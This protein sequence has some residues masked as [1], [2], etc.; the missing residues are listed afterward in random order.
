MEIWAPICHEGS[1]PRV[2]VCGIHDT[3]DQVT[4]NF[5]GLKIPEDGMDRLTNRPMRLRSSSTRNE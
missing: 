3:R 5:G 4:V 2:A 1:S